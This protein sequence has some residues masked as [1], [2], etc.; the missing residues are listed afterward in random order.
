MTE[1]TCAT[2]GCRFLVFRPDA[3]LCAYHVSTSRA[4]RRRRLAEIEA[5]DDGKTLCEYPN[6][7]ELAVK[8]GEGLRCA[9]HLV[10]TMPAA[11][12]R[13][14][15]PP[16]G[17]YRKVPNGGRPMLQHRL[18]MERHLGRSLATHENVHHLNGRRDDNRIENLELWSTSQPSGQ[19][20]GDKVVWAIE[21]LRQYRPEALAEG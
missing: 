6:C 20:I 8:Y 13:L 9:R 4:A 19:R 1:R 2:R 3:E 5:E 18:V 17:R 12:R 15:P 21:I 14:P 11:K 16:T 7:V 10:Q